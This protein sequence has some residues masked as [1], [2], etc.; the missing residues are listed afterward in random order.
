MKSMNKTDKR[1]CEILEGDILEFPNGEK[2][3]VQWKDS[4]LYTGFYLH[5]FKNNQNFVPEIFK[6]NE[7]KVVGQIL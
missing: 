5:D 2:Y 4:E 7:A 1:N 6:L 3:Y